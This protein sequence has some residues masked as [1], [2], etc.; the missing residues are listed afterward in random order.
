M[1]PC[2][3]DLWCSF[4]N[5]DFLGIDI[6]F[7]TF[8]EPLHEFMTM[9]FYESENQFLTCIQEPCIKRLDNIG[10]VMTIAIT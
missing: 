8:G 3:F 1:V 2:H 7:T 6:L 9:V 4:L 10:C 5:K